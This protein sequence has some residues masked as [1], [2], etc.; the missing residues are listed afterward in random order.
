MMPPLQLMS[1]VGREA[2]YYYELQQWRH[3]RMA[4]DGVQQGGDGKGLH[5][6]FLPGALLTLPQ[7]IQPHNAFTYRFCDKRTPASVLMQQAC[8]AQPACCAR[9]G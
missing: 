7:A 3:V 2:D 8:N 4:L 9:L 6:L 1:A 5:I